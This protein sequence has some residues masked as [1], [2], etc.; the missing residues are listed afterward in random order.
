M[1]ARQRAVPQR[2]GGNTWEK[3]T[4][5]EAI[6]A[7]FTKDA[8]QKKHWTTQE[9]YEELQK[10]KRK[11]LMTG[12]LVQIHQRCRAQQSP[13]PSKKNTKTS[14]KKKAIRS[15][16][17]GNVD[18]AVAKGNTEET[19]NIPSKSSFLWAS[20]TL[21]TYA[22]LMS[23]PS[24]PSWTLNSSIMCYRLHLDG[25]AVIETSRAKGRRCSWLSRLI[26]PSNRTNER[27]SLCH[28]WRLGSQLLARFEGGERGIDKTNQST[29]QGASHAGTRDDD[30]LIDSRRPTQRQRQQIAMSKI[31]TRQRSTLI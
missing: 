22:S 5:D 12:Q 25:Q 24:R 18:S 31:A 17:T 29:F 28:A 9:E 4:N 16:A 3:A 13:E 2:K 8:A 23:S 20:Q 7:D 26:R 21:M 6:G 15:M 11:L 10:G 27:R 1:V 30:D 19:S 14:S